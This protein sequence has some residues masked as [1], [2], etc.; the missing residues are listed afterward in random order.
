MPS[1]VSPSFVRMVEQMEI[2]NNK[3]TV[4]NKMNAYRG[5]LENVTITDIVQQ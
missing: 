4:K 2:N 3:N 5:T 1:H